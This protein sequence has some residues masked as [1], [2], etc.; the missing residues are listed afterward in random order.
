MQDS[1]QIY[2]WTELLAILAGVYLFPYVGIEFGSYLSNLIDK[3]INKSQ[4][5]YKTNNS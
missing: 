1:S 5:I 2:Q 3:K 4:E